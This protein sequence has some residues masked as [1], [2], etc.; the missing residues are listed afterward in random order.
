VTGEGDL[1]DQEGNHLAR[2]LGTW[3]IIHPQS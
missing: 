1:F 3:M 2:G